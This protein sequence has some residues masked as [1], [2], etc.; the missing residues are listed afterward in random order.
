MP[1]FK[2]QQII[3]G[4][5]LDLTENINRHHVF[6]LIPHLLHLLLADIVSSQDEQQHHSSWCQSAAMS[7]DMSK[8]RSHF[9]TAE[10]N[11]VIVLMGA[12]SQKSENSSFFQT[13]AATLNVSRHYPEELCATTQMSEAVGLDIRRT[14]LCQHLKSVSNVYSIKIDNVLLLTYQTSY[15]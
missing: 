3:C 8:D 10:T 13:C 4:M 11:D 9:W 7:F 14:F 6:L 2:G 1:H 5:K 15:V 12:L